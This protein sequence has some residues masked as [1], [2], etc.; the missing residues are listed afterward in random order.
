MSSKEQL[1][2]IFDKISKGEIKRPD[3][4]SKVNDLIKDL[5]D[6][7]SEISKDLE[8]VEPLSYLSV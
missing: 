4:K 5:D 6:K 7:D 3:V 2:F 1:R 8:H